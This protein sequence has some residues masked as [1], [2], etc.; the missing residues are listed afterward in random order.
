MKL[1]KKFR[2]EK[3]GEIS[4]N[5]PFSRFFVAIAE[6]DAINKDAEFASANSDAA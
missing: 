3:T 2:V 6:P 1:R 5:L 4:R